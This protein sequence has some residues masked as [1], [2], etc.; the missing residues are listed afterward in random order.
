MHYRNQLKALGKPIRRLVLRL[1]IPGS[2]AGVAVGQNALS[3]FAANLNW[4]NIDLT[5]YLHAGTHGITR[6]MD[7]V[8][9]VWLT[10]PAPIRAKGPDAVAKNL[11]GFDW[12][13]I[14]PFSSGGTSDASNGIFENARLNRARGARVMTAQE[15][16]AAHR[17]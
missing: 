10:I 8:H 15:I 2:T 9:R 12:S 13:H 16:R 1:P 14:V 5:K 17:S 4:A 7:E 6:G 3:D 11:A